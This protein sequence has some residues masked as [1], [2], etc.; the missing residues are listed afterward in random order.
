MSC[1]RAPSR[2]IATSD[3]GRCSCRA[4]D[5]RHLA[6]AL[7]MAGGI[8]VARIERRGQRPD[9]CRDT[10]RGSRSSAAVRPPISSLK[11]AARTSSSRLVPV[12]SSVRLK[13]RAPV[14][15]AMVA[16]DAVDR[17]GERAGQPQAGEGREHEGPQG[18]RRRAPPAHCALRPLAAASIDVSDV[19]ARR[20]RS[21]AAVRI[22]Y[23]SPLSVMVLRSS[24]IDAT[25]RPR[26]RI[27]GRAG[28]NAVVDGDDDARRPTGAP[29][30]ARSRCRGRCRRAACPPRGR[31]SR[32]GVLAKR[33]APAGQHR[34]AAG[35]PVGPTREIDHLAWRQRAAAGPPLREDAARGIQR[36]QR[37]PWTSTSPAARPPGHRRCCARRRRMLPG[38]GRVALAVVSVERR[39]RARSFR[40][41]SPAPASLFPL[42]LR[43][44]A[45][46]DALA[47]LQLRPVSAARTRSRASTR[48]TMNTTDRITATV[49]KVTPSVRVTRRGGCLHWAGTGSMKSTDAPRPGSTRTRH[50]GVAEPLV[51]RQ[52]AHDCPAERRQARTVRPRLES[53]TTGWL[54]T[55]TVADMCEWMSQNTL[56]MPGLSKR[57]TRLCPCG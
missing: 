54:R 53:R 25:T 29:A 4:D 15:V 48:S 17:I 52:P 3:S 28:H 46:V 2:M 5:H 33:N 20:R 31:P 42:P 26:R 56:T 27:A 16:R 14:I 30:R 41:A 21:R 47:D 44:E 35:R 38:A 43:L 6:D 49:M 8:R 19:D 37:C 9:A 23:S 13:S 12:G 32:S 22:A 57:T 36:R 10:R 40:R 18:N 24:P 51:P 55:I 50:R 7:G 11:L 34:H 39:L 1:S 45:R